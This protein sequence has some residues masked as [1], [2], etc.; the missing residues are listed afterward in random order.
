[1]ESIRHECKFKSETVA[2]RQYC[3]YQASLVGSDPS[4]RGANQSS[5]SLSSDQIALVY[6]CRDSVCIPRQSLEYQLPGLFFREGLRGHT[7]DPS[8][9]T[10]E[11][12]ISLRQSL[13]LLLQRQSSVAQRFLPS[14]FQR[15][16]H[17]SCSRILCQR[18]CSA[19]GCS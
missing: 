17:R 4:P 14:S 9:E 12:D 3:K 11:Q 13:R 18:S 8:R 16:R 10:R 6:H 7:V 5:D 1:M 2:H 19:G 15:P